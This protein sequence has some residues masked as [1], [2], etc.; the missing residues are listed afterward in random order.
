MGLRH[1]RP[2][3]LGHGEVDGDGLSERLDRSNPR[4]HRPE[5][6]GGR[7]AGIGCTQ[8]RV[9]QLVGQVRIDLRFP[10]GLHLGHDLAAIVERAILVDADLEQRG[11]R[12][13][14]LAVGAAV[15]DGV[16]E[17]VRDQPPDVARFQRVLAEADHTLDR[18]QPEPSRERH[19]A[20]VHEHAIG[21]VDPRGRVARLLQDLGR[22]GDHGQLVAGQ[23]PAADVDA[24]DR[25]E[26]G[27]GTALPLGRVHGLGPPR[28]L[29]GRRRDDRASTI[30]GALAVVQ[31]EQGRVVGAPLVRHRP[32]QLARA[33][34]GPLDDRLL[35]QRPAES[36]ALCARQGAVQI[37]HERGLAVADLAAVV[38]HAGAGRAHRAHHLGPGQLATSALLGRRQAD[39]ERDRGV[40]VD[41]ALAY[42]LS[43]LGRSASISGGS[44]LGTP[45]GYASSRY[46]RTESG[47]PLAFIQSTS[48]SRPVWG[49]DP[50]TSVDSS[51]D[52]LGMFD[53][54][55]LVLVPQLGGLAHGPAVRAPRR[56]Q[57]QRA[58]RLPRNGLHL[59]RQHPALLR[60]PAVGLGVQAV[61]AAVAGDAAVTGAGP[62][63]VP[64]LWRG[65]RQRAQQG[66]G[67]RVRVDRDVA[68]RAVGGDDVVVEAPDLVHPAQRVADILQ[69]AVLED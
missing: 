54:P 10:H 31:H 64:D 15:V 65:C 21:R 52:C 51:L 33:V 36:V 37:D 48:G 53:L 7:G 69:R 5:Q 27:V 45:S 26:P 13:H 24:L 6:T 9:A 17:L 57:V 50:A 58:H 43:S 2:H 55:L 40:A 38:E 23:I 25:V 4:I 49:A 16:G 44:G 56:G 30:A 11:P 12:G 63:V 29:L 19:V 32:E 61:G 14:E 28:D 46:R 18:D 35:V 47:S 34:H 41:P 22:R 8:E 67:H 62:E 60:G 3:L 68:R 39:V 59:P 42:L 66:R 1:V 20:S